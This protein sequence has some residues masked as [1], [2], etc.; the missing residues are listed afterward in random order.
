MT[1]LN[2]NLHLL[3]KENITL[4]GIRAVYAYQI[5]LNEIFMS[6]IVFLYETTYSFKL[7]FLYEAVPL[8]YTTSVTWQVKNMV[9]NNISKGSCVSRVG[10]RCSIDKKPPLIK[11]CTTR[12]TSIC[13]TIWNRRDLGT[14][15][16]IFWGGGAWV[17]FEQNFLALILAK[18][19]N[20]AQWHCEK[21]NLSPIVTQN[22][23]IGM[24]EM[25]KSKNFSG[26]LRSPEYY[27]K[28]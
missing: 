2:Q 16:L 1:N 28:I 3:S 18:K 5:L 13:L 14:V 12:L 20:L 8:W 24:L 6:S 23:L 4:V 21:N 22:S 26:S 17:F 11:R 10:G 9:T 15:H 27:I 19:N 25:S 7:F